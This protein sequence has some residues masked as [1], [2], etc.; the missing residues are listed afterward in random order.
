[1]ISSFSQ[2][3]LSRPKLSAMQ[4]ASQKANQMSNHMANASLLDARLAL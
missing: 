1:M 3:A 4:M 2:I